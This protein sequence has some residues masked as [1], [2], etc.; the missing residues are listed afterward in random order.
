MTL[1]R[2]IPSVLV[3]LSVQAAAD[4]VPV[5]LRC[6]GQTDLAVVR[7]TPELSWRVESASRGQAQSAW[8]IL[9]ASNPRTLAEGKGDL[10]DS[11][12]IAAGR[13]PFMRYAGKPL[14]AGQRCH[15]KVRCWDA[16]L[17]PPGP[18][19]PPPPDRRSATASI[20]ARNVTPGCPSSAGTG[21]ASTPP[22]GSPCG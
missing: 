21:P 18:V 1:Y 17:S 12:K 15:W 11:G 14:A 4:L 6:D 8:Q 20:S 7:A 22:N 5:D 19:G 3:A 9:V 2:L 16:D 13:S 10:W